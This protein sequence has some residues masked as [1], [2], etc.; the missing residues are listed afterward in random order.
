MI[1]QWLERGW[2]F[3]QGQPCC[4]KESFPFLAQEIKTYNRGMLMQ[5]PSE[6]KSKLRVWLAFLCLF[7]VFAALS[8]GAWYIAGLARLAETHAARESQTAPQV[9]A[10][11]SPIDEAL[12]Q[13]P[14]NKLLQMVAMATRAAKDT[15]AAAEK[16]SNEVEQPPIP[17]GINLAALSRA[18]LEALRR[19]LK[20]AEAN[21]T[22][23]MPRYAALLKAEREAIEKEALS[24]RVEKEALGKLLD[25]VDQRHAELTAFT[26]RMM[27][28]RAEFYRAYESLV[29]VIAGEAGAYKV[30]DGQF[31]FQFQR[32]VDRYNV[33]THATAV[34]AKRV[35]EL[36]EEKKSLETS[37]QAAW[38]QF[39]SGK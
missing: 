21:A 22:A 5:T 33:A 26:A 9:V 17:A 23:F 13:R 19:N 27:S 7:V 14:S 6:S 25:A 36:A 8:Y 35:G 10:A 3:L 39:V 11:P 31:V 37:Q 12:R 16:L 15:S 30:A 4:F 34:A 18:D 24:S 20:T 2:R 1:L 38:V 28:A 29:A 32:T